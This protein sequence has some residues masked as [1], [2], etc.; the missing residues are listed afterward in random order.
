MATVLVVDDQ[1]AARRVL[2]SRLDAAGF[3]VLQA[4]DGAEAW[5]K[6]EAREPQLV[7]TDMAMPQSDG[8]DLT[9]RIRECSDVPIIVFS[10]Y[11]SVPAAVSAVKAGAS[12]FLSSADLDVDALVGLARNLCDLDAHGSEVPELASRLPGSSTAI[13][14]VRARLAALASLRAPV[15]ITGEPGSGRTTAA[16]AL[17][18]HGATAGLDFHKVDAAR[19]APSAPVPKQGMVLLRGVEQLSPGGQAF[20]KERLAGMSGERPLRIV[21]SSAG[22]WDRGTLIE[23]DLAKALLRF[24]VHLPP[25]RDRPEDIPDIAGALLA[26]ISGRL[27]RERPRVEPAAFDLLCAQTWPGNATQL[28]QLLERAVAYSRGRRLTRGEIDELLGESR[29]SLATVRREHEGRTRTELLTALRESAGNI[30]R[31]AMRLGLSRQ[32]VY[33]LLEKHS[34]SV[35]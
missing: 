26:R 34:I 25:L 5:R 8:I 10:A 28:S 24:R 22:D 7:I 6:F 15:L 31:T 1:R 33:R 35:D 21:A 23:T 11:G 30:S 19:F 32:S 12:E 29:E 9:G 18:E 17:H 13:T 14:R 20:W 27:G 3:E 4:A 16:R 2:A